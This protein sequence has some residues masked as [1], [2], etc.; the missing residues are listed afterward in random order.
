M[1]RSGDLTT[2]AH[3]GG[4]RPRYDQDGYRLRFDWGA[5]GLAA[6]APVADVVVIVDVLRFTTCVDVA[7]AR[8]ALVY[9][10]P[11]RDASAAQ[12]GASRG[13]EIAGMREDP[14]TPWSLSPTDLGTIP[15]GTRLV[16]P[17]PNGSALAHTAQTFGVSVFAGCLRNASAVAE[18]ALGAGEIVAVVAAGERWDRHGGPLRPAVEDLLGAGAVIASAID[19]LGG[20]H[21]ASIDAQGAAAVF[22]A[23]RGDLSSALADCG[24]GRELVAR[25]WA[26]DVE[27]AAAHD[28][29]S[30]APVLRS[31]AFVASRCATM[32]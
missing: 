20:T 25:G 19:R 17:S 21:A 28:V 3:P 13:A 6:L 12:F 27:V 15:S 5:D 16:L 29:S 9:P 11:W 8:G 23:L 4:Q 10:Y 7:V 1:A 32:A 26:D 24:S 31:G 2:D 14:A 18:A 30:C 22:G